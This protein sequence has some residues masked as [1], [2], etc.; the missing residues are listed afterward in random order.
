MKKK[1][2]IIRAIAHSLNPTIRRENVQRRILRIA[3]E[4]EELRRRR[5]EE[6]DAESGKGA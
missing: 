2:S 4:Q 5:R 6:R 3:R 1:R